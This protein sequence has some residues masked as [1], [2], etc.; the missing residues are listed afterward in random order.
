MKPDQFKRWFNRSFWKVFKDQTLPIRIPETL[1]EKAALI[2]TLYDAISSAR[3]APS[4]PEAEMVMNKGHGVARTVPVF[5]IEDYCVYYF[6]IKELEDIL[7]VNRTPNT[8]G[9]WTL[10]G[11]LRQAENADIECELT[12]YGRYSFNPRAWTHAFNEFN[13]LLFAQL[14]Q[15]NYSHVLQF[16]LS[17]FYDSVR[18]DTLERWIREEAPSE[19]GWIVTLLFYLLNQWNR[20]NTGLHPQSVGLPQD[21]LADCSRILANYYLQ[22]YDQFAEAICTDNSALYFRYA[23]DQMLLLNDSAIV[24]RLLLLLTRRLDR[25]GLRVNQKKVD[26][27]TAAE[28]QEH[29]CRAIQSIF[30]E[31]GDSQDPALVRRFVDAYLAIPKSDLEKAW[32]RGLPLLNRLLWSNLESLPKSLFQAVLVRLSS[33]EYLLRA[34]H[35]KLARVHQ[36]NRSRIRPIDLALRLRRIGEQ[37]VHNAYHYEVLA[38][39]KSMRDRELSLF[40]ETRLASLDELMNSM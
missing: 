23:D 18:L 14:D 7:S 4:I 9:G 16:D 10:G 20:R 38:F 36:L 11:K 34:D 39:A 1:T 26:L 22:K 37:S 33:D 3:Y 2:D 15:G 8:F 13:S 30:K 25:Y 6:C 29:R 32:N 31:S 35:K 24:E 28:L 5:C 27:W 19:K 12:E 17:N 21:A 40:C